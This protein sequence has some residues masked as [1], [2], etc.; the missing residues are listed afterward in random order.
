MV[1]GGS[2]CRACPGDT[3]TPAANG[4]DRSGQFGTV[5][6]QQIG[7]KCDPVGGGNVWQPDDAGV[8]RAKKVN[9]RA[10][11]TVYRHENAA[12]VRRYAQQSPVARIRLL[13]PGRPHVVSLR[14]QPRGQT[15]AS[16]AIDQEFQT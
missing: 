11:V 13:L 9:E 8:W 3:N 1:V 14:C 10:E 5:T 4:D 6:G 16:T 2:G 7:H 15:L 12:F